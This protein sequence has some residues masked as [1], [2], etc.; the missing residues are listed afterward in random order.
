MR[1]ANVP[2]R[3]QKPWLLRRARGAS[4]LVVLSLFVAAGCSEEVG[5]DGFVPDRP[6]SAGK[7][8]GGSGGLANVPSGG[9]MDVGGEPDT[10]TAGTG[11]RSHGGS[12]GKSSGGKAGTAPMDG[13]AGGDT[14]TNK[15][16]CGNGA[17]EPGEQCDDG[18]TKSGDGCTADCLKD[19][20]VCE[21][22][23]CTAVRGALAGDNGWVQEDKKSP[24]NLYSGPKGC[25]EL[26]GTASPAG[27]AGAVPRSELCAAMVDCIRR[28]KCEQLLP[29]DTPDPKSARD[30][31]PAVALPFMRCYCDLDVTDGFSTKCG[32]PAQFKAGKCKREIQEAS[33]GQEVNNVLMGLITGGKPLGVGN[34]LLQACD[35]SL[36][37]EE[38]LP[39]YTSGIVAQISGDILVAKNE[40]GE[41]PVGD[42]IADAQRAAMQTD[43]AFVNETTYVFYLSSHGLI[44]RAATGR[45]AD[46][47]GRVLESEVRQL[48]FGMDQTGTA[49][50]QAGGTKLVTLQLTGQQVQE[51]LNKNYTSTQVSG[52]AYTWSGASGVTEVR[53]GGAP[54]DKA[55]TYTI[56]VN[57]TLVASIAGATNIASS[58]KSPEQELVSYLRAQP[59]PVAP[60]TLN[61]VTKLN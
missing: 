27:P 10:S 6:I 8:G 40:A 43:F 4:A 24:N 34:L 30:Y 47:D 57:S 53:K 23:F 32:N 28:E 39:G 55:A 59:Q 11:G 44:F 48:V 49:V 56:T 25:F 5:G 9:M 31:S 54:I 52:L 46:A 41:S 20:E 36:C 7:A 12:G 50:N 18:N 22:T 38:C 16:V 45:P 2:S 15:S 14:N 58:D 60:P 26:E 3:G 29:I 61:R 51:F 33:E 19:C 37:T 17:I 21:K 13:G 1:G 42:L 35:K